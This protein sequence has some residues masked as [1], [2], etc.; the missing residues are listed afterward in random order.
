MRNLLHIAL[1]LLLARVLSFFMPWWS[2][3]LAAFVVALIMARKSG[4]AFLSGFLGIFLLWGGYA[5]FYNQQN[6]GALAAKMGDL[7]GGLSP[8]LLVLITAFLGGLLG[9]LSSLSGYW[10]KGLIRNDS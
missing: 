9:G 4:S 6:D 3:A 5:F 1:V 8:I 7:F 10:A 2:L